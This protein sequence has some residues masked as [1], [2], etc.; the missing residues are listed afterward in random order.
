M[1][2]ISALKYLPYLSAASSS[3]CGLLVA[4]MTSVL[5][6]SEDDIY[7]THGMRI[8]DSNERVRREK[9]R[10]MIDKHTHTHSLTHSYPI[11]GKEELI[12]EPSH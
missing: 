9:G 10:Q 11:K 1:W 4:A 7:S 12:L 3:S 5:S 2:L 6:P 8:E